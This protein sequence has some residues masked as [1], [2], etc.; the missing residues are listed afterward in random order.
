MLDQTRPG[1]LADLTRREE[2]PQAC[3]QSHRVRDVLLIQ[4]SAKGS[5]PGPKNGSRVWKHDAHASFL[6]V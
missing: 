4:I 1:Q 3:R 6:S 5:E 2:A